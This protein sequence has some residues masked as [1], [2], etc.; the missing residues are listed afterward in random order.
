MIRRLYA[1]VD[2][3]W[4]SSCVFPNFQFGKKEAG[5]I[6]N[7]TL[8]VDEASIFLYFQ[9][10]LLICPYLIWN[11]HKNDHQLNNETLI[12]LTL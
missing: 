2:I 4:L 5:S 7:L 11:A 12:V 1:Q 8:Q 9:I 6:V 10:I 3:V